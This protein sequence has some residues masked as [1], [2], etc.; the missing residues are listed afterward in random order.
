MNKTPYWIFLSIEACLCF[1][2][3]KKLAPLAIKSGSIAKLAGVVVAVVPWSLVVGAGYYSY[4]K[5][6]GFAA[7][8]QAARA[9]GPQNFSK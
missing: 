5:L 8:R 2:A 7:A 4:K 6:S 3:L 1:I 9:G